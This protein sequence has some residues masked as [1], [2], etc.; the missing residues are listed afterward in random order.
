MK[1]PISWLNE[2]VDVSEVSVKELCDAL[3][4][5]GFEVEEVIKYSSDISGVVT[6]KILSINKHENADKLKVCNVDIGDKTLV[7]V[8]GADNVNVGDVVPVALDGAL[9]GN[10][11]IKS[12]PL[13]GVMSYGMM[14]SG[15]ELKTD[16]AFIDGASVNGIL[17]L[18]K[19]LPLG[20]DVIK[21]LNL[22]ETVLDVAIT[23]NRAD[24]HSILGLA[25]EVSA[26]LNI[27]MKSPSFDYNYISSDIKIPSVKVTS[28]DCS[29]YTGALITN[30]KIEPSPKWMQRR[31]FMCGV[32]PINNV[33]DITN[34]V[35]MEIGQPLHAFDLRFIQGSVVV[36]RANC[37]EEIVALNGE[38]YKL[39][40][41]MTVICDETKPLAIAGVMGGEGS[42]IND[43][44]ANVFLESA[45]FLRGS[46]RATSRKLGLRSDSSARF[47]R[48]VDYYSVEAGRKRALSLF[49]LLCAGTPVVETELDNIPK[50][51]ISTTQKQIN[52][53]LGISVPVKKSVEILTNLGFDVANS[54]DKLTI[55]VPSFREDIDN[56]TDIAEEVIRFY[57]CD[58]LKET[59]MTSA[60]VTIGGLSE[61][62]KRINAVK[63]IALS[64]GCYEILT[65]SFTDRKVFDKLLLSESDSRR[66]AIAIRNPITEDLSI[67]KTELVSG[68]VSVIS[69]NVQRKNG[70]F[71]LMELAK[72]YNG[73]LPLTELPK[74]NSV[75]CVGGVDCDFYDIKA[76]FT[77]V[78]RSFDVQYTIERSKEPYLHPGIS[79]D[80]IVDGEAIASFGKLHPSVMKN[81]G[82]KNGEIFVGSLNVERL[83]CDKT[84]PHRYS[85][86]PKFPPVERDLALVV[87]D[88]VQVGDIIQAIE[89]ADSMIREVR[90]FDV[91]KGEQIQKGYKSVAI[92]FKIVS[93]D[94]T[95]VDNEIVQIISNV[96]NTLAKRFNAKVRA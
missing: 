85:P 47:E 74:E 56:F 45:R 26:A 49:S 11:V 27:P 12:A 1:L 25:R 61:K 48:G 35:L 39:D 72:V 32:R 57:G 19:N 63:Q 38:N 69:T 60:A 17:L 10:K 84:V 23:A 80:L 6:G 66:N 54:G 7:I 29:A 2:Y 77:T 93:Y 51:V 76:V 28:P 96:I 22:D 79:A 90:L 82:I 83:L 75:L 16:D 94:K 21:L 18:D 42:G 40:D 88:D 87:N 3:V 81:F 58:K 13:R 44:T 14:C 36:R 64:L 8:T 70:N 24:C 9:L 67:M 31:L 50:K 73:N 34:Y 37:G 4:G 92:K 95:L 15:A 41:T 43:D 53:I 86:L 46:V 33:V 91:Y 59:M 52:S 55:T 78:L 5:A 68:M 62:Q 65:Y 89:Q 20:K 71:M 30:I